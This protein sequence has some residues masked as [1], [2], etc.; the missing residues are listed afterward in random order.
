M[1]KLEKLVI[2]NLPR[3]HYED[4]IVEMLRKEFNITNIELN[5]RGLLSS[6]KEIDIYLPDYKVGIEFNGE[7]WHCDLH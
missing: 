3:S 7:Y 4:E 5:K 6:G 1:M 2:W